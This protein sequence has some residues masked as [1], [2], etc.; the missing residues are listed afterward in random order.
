M[1]S[2]ETWLRWW[3]ANPH[4]RVCAR[5]RIEDSPLAGTDDSVPRGEHGVLCDVLRS[6]A[7]LAV[8]FGRDRILLCAPDEV[9]PSA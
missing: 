7:L 2:A 6:D 8:D 9:A 1:R 5:H 4:G 3:A